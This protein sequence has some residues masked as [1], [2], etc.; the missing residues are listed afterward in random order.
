MPA[1]ADPISDFYSGKQIT[2]ICATGPSGDYAIYSQLV[3]RHIGRHIPGNPKVR[4]QFMPGAG[5]I[6]GANHMYTLAP[7]DGTVRSLVCRYRPYR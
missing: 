2:F 1:V 3:V 7:K 5:G 4:I 6:I